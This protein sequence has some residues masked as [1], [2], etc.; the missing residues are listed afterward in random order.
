MDY[1]SR[2]TWWKGNPATRVPKSNVVNTDLSVLP[3]TQ[4]STGL[5]ETPI[6]PKKVFKKGYSTSQTVGVSGSMKNVFKPTKMVKVKTSR[7]LDLHGVADSSQVL[8]VMHPSELSL[9]ESLIRQEAF[10]V[11]NDHKVIDISSHSWPIDL[12]K[13]IDART[14]LGVAVKHGDELGFVAS[15]SGEIITFRNREG[16]RYVALQDLDIV[17]GK[18]TQ[19]AGVSFVTGD[20]VMTQDGM[21]V[22]EVTD[23]INE[24]DNNS[25]VQVRWDRSGAVASVS[26]SDIVGLF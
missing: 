25:L 2:P 20:K 18:I 22:G 19:Q 17:P 3:D 12:F 23:P 9:L 5:E 14:K 24:Q 6:G 4:V 10:L 15:C 11:T 7:V 8:V 16:R 26:S 1:Q 21:M 13:A